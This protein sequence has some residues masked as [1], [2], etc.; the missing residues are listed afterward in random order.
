MYFPED[1]DWEQNSG[2]VSEDRQAV[3]RM[4]SLIQEVITR[5]DGRMQVIVT[6]HANIDEPWF[7]ESITERWREGVALIPD[8]WIAS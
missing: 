1:R 8:S 3:A 6:D 4:Y 2:V 7:Q 5:L